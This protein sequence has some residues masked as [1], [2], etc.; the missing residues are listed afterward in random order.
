MSDDVPAITPKMA[1]AGRQVLCYSGALTDPSVEPDTEL[2]KKVFRA[3]WRA[4]PTPSTPLPHEQQE[5]K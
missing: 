4:G 1:E 2:A 5:Q 3:M